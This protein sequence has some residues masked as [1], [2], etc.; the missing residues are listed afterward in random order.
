MRKTTNRLIQRPWRRISCPPPG[1]KVVK[2]SSCVCLCTSELTVACL[3][4]WG[5]MLMSEIRST[6]VVS[7]LGGLDL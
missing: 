5:W 2:V 4:C 1:A 3:C 7:Q 6:F